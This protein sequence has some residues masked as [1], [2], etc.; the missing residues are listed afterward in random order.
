MFSIY[1]IDRVP[2]RGACAKGDDRLQIRENTAVI[3]LFG[4]R[5]K[6]FPPLVENIS[7]LL[8][9]IGHLWGLLVGFLVFY[10]I[11]SAPIIFNQFVA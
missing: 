4:N 7:T 8:H 11:E 5:D 9:E 6:Y 2:T 3:K 10:E 1:H